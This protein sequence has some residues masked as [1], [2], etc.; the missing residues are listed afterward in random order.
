MKLAFT[1]VSAAFLLVAPQA[2]ADEPSYINEL[3]AH[4]VFAPV[5]PNQEIK[6]GHAVCDSLRAG[7]PRPAANQFLMVQQPWADPIIDAAQHQLC[8]D[9]LH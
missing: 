7:N 1:L 2:H 6:M 9:T 5:G 3:N 4:G 8:P